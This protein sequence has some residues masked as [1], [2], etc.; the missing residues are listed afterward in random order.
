MNNSTHNQKPAATFRKAFTLIELLVVIAIIAI[1]AAMLLPALAKAKRKAQGIK[2][3]SNLK[4]IGLVMAMYTG[5]NRDYFPSATGASWWKFPLIDLPGLQNPYIST[6]NRAFYLC[7][8][9]VTPKG[10]NYQLAS[11][12][13]W[14]G[15]GSGKTAA[16]LPFPCSYYYYSQ[17]YSSATDSSGQPINPPYKV[18]MVNFPVEKAIQQCQA[19]GSLAFFE[20]DYVAGQDPMASAHGKGMSL[21]FV[22]SHAQFAPYTKLNTW[23]NGS[24][25]PCY[26]FDTS[27]LQKRQDLK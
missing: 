5:D 4:Q 18:S 17:F 24:G 16:D 1:L 23:N 10:W 25:G 7:P 13:T 14:A 6:N 27:P 9:D 12:P 2:C 8:S 19:S 22:D 26:N 3:V 15:D 11:N 21:L 20:T